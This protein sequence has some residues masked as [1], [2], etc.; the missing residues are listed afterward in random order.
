M[1]AGDIIVAFDGVKVKTFSDLTDLIGKKAVN[2]PF[3]VRVLDDEVDLAG[4]EG[5]VGL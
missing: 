1:H 2:D 5:A 4:P 3:E